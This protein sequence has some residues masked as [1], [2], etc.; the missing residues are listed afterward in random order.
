MYTNVLIC[1]TLLLCK[2]LKLVRKEENITNSNFKKI[3]QRNNQ[4]AKSYYVIYEKYW[5]DT[6]Q[7]I[8]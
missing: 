8:I 5:N 4:I 3:L 2:Y 6:K 1:I 7:N